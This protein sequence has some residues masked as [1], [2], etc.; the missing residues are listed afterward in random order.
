MKLADKAADR[1]DIDLAR[2]S[3]PGAYVLLTDELVEA[4][5][6]TAEGEFPQF[7]HFLEVGRITSSES[8]LSS[9]KEQY[10][11]CPAALARFLVENVSLNDAFRIQSVQKVDGEWEYK[12]EFVELEESDDGISLA[13]A[14]GDD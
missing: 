11:E 2:E 4:D 5:E 7:G 6:L 12:C 13:E 1:P 14:A 9:Y 10:I 3:A 8:P